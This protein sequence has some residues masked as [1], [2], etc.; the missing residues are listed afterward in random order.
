[1]ID[2]NL[3][4]SNKRKRL[5]GWFGLE[6]NISRE[7][8]LGVGAAVFFLLFVVH[9]F[10]AI[11]WIISSV[12]LA[13]VEAK[14][15]QLLPDKNALDAISNEV[16]AVNKKMKAIAGFV[17]VRTSGLSQK[18]N[19]ISDALPKGVWLTKIAVD[20]KAWV[21][22]G[23]AVAKQHNEIVLV[24]TLTSNLKKNA[25]LMADFSLLEVTAVN[26]VKY[27]TIDVSQFTITA[28]VK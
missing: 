17:P 14:Y 10:L 11:N 22:S 6:L 13:G 16:K 9:I 19:I 7:I 23:I 3:M 5:D 26:R 20:E 4:P 25:D 21:V 2:I 18:L 15:K 1:M 28:K 24:S 12:Q 8:L 27:N